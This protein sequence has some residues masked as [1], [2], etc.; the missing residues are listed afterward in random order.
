MLK[1]LKTKFYPVNVDAKIIHDDPEN[2][3]RDVARKWPSSV[4]G[5]PGKRLMGH[6]CYDSY[7]V[8]AKA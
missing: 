2:R 7:S 1:L 6:K 8:T 4:I 3:E 5:I